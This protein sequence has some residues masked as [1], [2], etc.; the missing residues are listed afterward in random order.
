MLADI[1][2]DFF[3]GDLE[4]LERMAHFSWR[5]EYGIESFPN[6]YRPAFLNYLFDRIKDDR[7]L[8]AAYRGDEIVSFLAN[9]PQKFYFQGK[10]YRAVYSCLMVTKKELL[11]RGLGKAIIS[12]ALKMNKSFNI[13]FS[14]L[15]LEK[16]HRSTAMIRSFEETGHPVE[17]V[18]RNHVVARV[19][20][21]PGVTESEGLKQWERAAIKIIGA[22][23]KPK[24]A[25]PI[26]VREYKSE[27]IDE[28]LNLLNQYKDR[29]PL[30]LIW[31]RDELA[32]ELDFL[33]VSQ[34]LVYEKAGRVEGLINFIYHQHLGKTKK[35]WAWI[36]HVAY[37]ELTAGERYD[38]IQAFLQ[39]IKKAGCVGAIE[40]TK[41]YYSMSPLYRSRFFPYFRSVDLV[42]WTFNKDISLENIS[43]VYEVQI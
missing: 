42:S 7:Y 16:G 40:W 17:R 28:C 38:F 34:T 1:T 32:C 29:I 9:L 30:A 27:D 19:L 26:W 2:I 13:D 22:H 11:H 23:R 43:S 39:Y 12:E 18:K 10:I 6:F 5:D 24:K 15:T 25:F 8:I 14:L 20:D 35:R 41:N 37:P 21:L 4:E 33:D 36:N 3:R 31:N